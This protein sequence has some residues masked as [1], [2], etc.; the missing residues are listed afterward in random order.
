[1]RA[2]PRVL[3]LEPAAQGMALELLE[4]AME[5]A[6]HD[7]LPVS[8]AAWCHGL[9]A[10]HHFTPRRNEEKEQARA[11]AARAARLN[12]GDALAETMLAAGYT[13]AHD[14]TAAKVHVERALTLDGTSA[15]AWGRHAWIKAYRGQANEAI[16]CF[17]IARSLAPFDR[18]HFLCCHG[19][20]SSMF[21]AGRYEESIAWFK[22]GIAE[23][24][25]A[26]WISRW[27]VAAYVLAGRKDEG[28]HTLAQLRKADP[29]LTIT[30]V[31][32]GL[33]WHSD[34]LDRVADGLETAGMHR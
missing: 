22:R 8:I 9:R 25:A 31:R 24:R 19:I 17:Q 6:P 1:M 18:L 29:E 27:L 30:D 3:S 10:G 5:L 20:A 7:A 28:R 11:L 34:F 2:L 14:L 15:W 16:E 13:L 12:T 21:D 33:P 32:S 23:N 26:L 4:R